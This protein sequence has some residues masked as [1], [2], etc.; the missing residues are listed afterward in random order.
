MRKIILQMMTTLNGRVDDPDVWISGIPDDLY[1]EIDRVYA[2]F[3]TV[4]AGQST[5]TEMEAYWPGAAD[6]A[7]SSATTKSMAHKMNT[8]Q[9]ILISS[10]PKKSLT[11]KN[12][13]QATVRNDEE[14]ARLIHGLKGQP[15]GDIHLAGGAR[16][17]QSV[18]RL[19]LVDEYHCYLY[20]VLSYGSAWFDQI[21][22]KR[23]L[24]LI[25]A[26]PYSGGVVAL[27]YRQIS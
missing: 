12:S 3:D 26:T 14:L 6:E 22:E 23:E 10:G 2:T 8:Y 15:G 16:L 13:E 19:G 20:P 24:A 27:Y 18:V 7:G 4:L 17:A 9:K 21:E 1:A 5:Y 25:S 11:W